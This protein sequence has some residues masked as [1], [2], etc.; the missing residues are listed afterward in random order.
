LLE[1]GAG[2]ADGRAGRCVKGFE[3]LV[4]GLQQ[5]RR[6]RGVGSAFDEEIALAVDR[7]E[8][9]LFDLQQSV[10][11]AGHG[12]RVAEIG[13]QNGDFARGG[14]V[15]GLQ[16]GSPELG[17]DRRPGKEVGMDDLMRVAAQQEM[18]LGFE[19]I[20]DQRE[21]GVSEILHF[22][23]DDEIVARLGFRAPRL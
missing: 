14:R 18:I 22:V 4:L 9:C 13:L 11:E 3:S 8:P 21:L 12:L 20:E 16:R 23:D 19:R 17:A 2:V 7:A 6:A 5:L 1:A 10:G 15:L